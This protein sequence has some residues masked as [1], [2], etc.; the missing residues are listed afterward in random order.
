MGDYI[1]SVS[2][3]Q[4][5]AKEY[6]E[7]T[8]LFESSIQ[9]YSNKDSFSVNGTCAVSNWQGWQKSKMFL[10]KEAVQWNSHV[11]DLSS[12]GTCSE[13]VN[14]DVAVSS[15]GTPPS[16]TPPP[17][18]AASLL[19]PPP[20]PPP[21]PTTATQQRASAMHVSSASIGRNEM[22]AHKEHLLFRSGSSS[23]SKAVRHAR[24]ALVHWPENVQ[25]RLDL[26]KTLLFEECGQDEQVWEYNSRVQ[27]GLSHCKTVVT[28]TRRT[29]RALLVESKKNSTRTTNNAT[30]NELVSLRDSLSVFVADA[31]QMIGDAHASENRRTK[32]SHA[33]S[34]YTLALLHA[35]DR[36]DIRQALAKCLN[37]TD[38]KHTE[39]KQD[40]H[41]S[42]R[43]ADTPTSASTTAAATTSTITSTTQ[44]I[45][46]LLSQHAVLASNDNMHFSC[47]M[48]GECCRHADYIFLSPIDLWRML[49]AP[50]MSH[51]RKKWLSS[52]TKDKD[53]D[54]DKENRSMAALNR[55]LGGALKW[56]TKKG[57]PIC[58][59]SPKQ[60]Q[61]R[62]HFAYPLYR[63]HSTGTTSTLLPPEKAWSLE[64][65]HL[66]THQHVGGVNETDTNN[67]PQDEATFVP[68]VESEV[69]F[70]PEDYK[71]WQNKD[72]KTDPKRKPKEEDHETKEA[73]ESGE[74]GEVGEAG[75]AGEAGEANDEEDEEDEDD[76][77]EQASKT[78]K[79]FKTF[80]TPK[81][82]QKPKTTQHLQVD[83][84]S[85]TPIINTFG[86]AALGCSLGSEHMPTMCSS[87]PLARE[88]TLADFWHQDDSQVLGANSEHNN[89]VLIHNNAC[90]GLFV[91][92]SEITSLTAEQ[93]FVPMESTSTD[94]ISTD[95]TPREASKHKENASKESTFGSEINQSKPRFNR[96]V[97]DFLSDNQLNHRW[98]EQDWFVSMMND[99]T[100]TGKTGLKLLLVFS[101]HTNSTIIQSLYYS[102]LGNI[103]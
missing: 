98:K 79:T 80:K 44:D 52:T 19:P 18:P 11:R 43:V 95:S 62:C 47:T 103:W 92:G 13:Y 56:T 60:Q 59:L 91:P 78:F 74:A 85:A 53:K 48:C 36:I 23:Y 102:G 50:V 8:S 39:A 93:S 1:V 70:T 46:D 24:K 75:D 45:E 86:R 14:R 25:Y 28:E 88:L 57:L 21:P 72:Q 99:L 26:A 63:K 100:S 89:Y 40:K 22:A 37:W 29:Q 69:D 71:A 67:G 66:S 55:M 41:K 34:A 49:K 87:Y 5:V 33:I 3:K 82:P 10:G 84:L 31:Y 32:I 68:V 38:N 42:L 9:I 12:I 83:E 6:F 35:P 96:S 97:S 81:T 77:E 51:K 4:D 20:H 54:K 64:V 61:S 16:K 7:N 94:S 58:Y 2:I 65:H 30:H 73:G 27:E 90:E 76:Y 15:T 101:S 17:V